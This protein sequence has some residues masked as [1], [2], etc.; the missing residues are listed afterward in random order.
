[1]VEKDLIWVRVS[2]RIGQV[3][4]DIIFSTIPVIIIVVITLCATD[5]NNSATNS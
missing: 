2:S 3:I 4:S 1:M 5:L